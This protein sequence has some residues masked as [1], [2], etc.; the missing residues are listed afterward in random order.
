MGYFIGSD[1]FSNF[2]EKPFP[3]TLP[4]SQNSF[5]YGLELEFLIAKKDDLTPLWHYDLSF[6]YLN[7][8]LEEVPLFDFMKRY[9]HGMKHL[10]IEHPHTKLM[11]YL[12]EGYHLPNENFEMKSILPKGIEIRTPVC[13]SIK[14]CLEVSL[15]L[16]NLLRTTLEQYGLTLLTI[17]HHP[18][19][20]KFYERPNKRRYDYWKW[21]MEAMTTYGPD[22]NISLPSEILK[23]FDR[24]DFDSKLNYY[25]PAMTSL[26]LNSSLVNRSVW[27]YRDEVGQSYR[28]FKRSTYA[29]PIEYHGNEENRIEFKTFEMSPFLDDYELYFIL[30]LTLLLDQ[31]LKGRSTPFSLIHE[32]G[33]VALKGSEAPTIHSKLEELILSAQKTLPEFGIALPSSSKLEEK[34]QSQKSVGYEVARLYTERGAKSAYQFLNF[35]GYK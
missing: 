1:T 17:S 24:Q 29:P 25:A 14:E 26:C 12:V 30:A 19:H 31:G 22:I 8:I 15:E 34:L 6:E 20:S 9:E 11:P 27:N 3:I 4:C 23:K 28:T 33:E 21:A 5:Q 2:I 18:I 10:R 7:K 35:F 32:L 13:T 16:Y